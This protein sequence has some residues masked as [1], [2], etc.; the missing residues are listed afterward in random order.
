MNKENIIIR[1]ATIEDRTTI[2]QVVAMA[3]GG[4]PATHPLYPVFWELAGYES[5]QY[6]YRNALIAE[7]NGKPV[8]AIV[9]YDGARL[10]ELRKPIF[11]LIQKHLGKTIEIEDETQ[12]G[13]FYLD[14]VAVF[15]SYQGLGIGRM[16]I[17]AMRDKAFSEGHERF[18]LIVDVDNPRAEALYHSIGFKRIN[19]TTFLGHKMWHLQIVKR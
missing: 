13:E 14:S 17:E 10:H 16:L 5:A 18:G 2:A 11:P 6:S 19:P 4:D 12:A 15:P 1:P 7:L 3:L 9:G 8:G